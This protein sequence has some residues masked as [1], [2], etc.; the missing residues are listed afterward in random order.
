MTAQGL[1]DRVGVSRGMIHRIERGDPRCEIGVVFELASLLGIALM[2]R[3]LPLS[4]VSETLEAKLAVLPQAVRPASRE[5]SD[6]F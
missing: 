2:A 6:D 4:I 5:V 1:A 3:D